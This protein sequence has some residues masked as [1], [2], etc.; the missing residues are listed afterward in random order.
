MLTT[1]QKVYLRSEAQKIKSV[2]QVGHDGM[3]N[4]M[5]TDIRK[6]LE[7]HELIKISVLKSCPIDKKEVA[8]TLVNCGFELVQ[9]IGSVVIIYHKSKKAKKNF[10]LPSN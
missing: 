6:Y 2:F 10:E 4:N 9:I 1:K 5:I 7:K 8:E 3:N